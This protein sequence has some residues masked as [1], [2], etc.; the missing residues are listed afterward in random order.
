[1]THVLILFISYVFSLISK[2]MIGYGLTMLLV[3]V[4]QQYKHSARE[5]KKKDQKA[6]KKAEKA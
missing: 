4:F 2:W 6:K 1:M 5:Q 3:L